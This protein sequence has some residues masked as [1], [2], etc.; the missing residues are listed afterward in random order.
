MGSGPAPDALSSGDGSSGPDVFERLPWRERV[1][2]GD[3]LRQETV[4]GALLLIAAL[5][6]LIWA[7][8]PWR[9]A[10]YDLASTKVGPAALNLNLSLSTWAA[11]GLLAIFFYVAG[12]ELKRELVVGTLRKPAEAVLPVAAALGGMIVPALIFV[13]VAWGNSPDIT[14]WGIPMATDIAFALAVLAVVGRN[15]PAQLRA[16]LLTLAVVD[17]LGAITVIALF[18]SDKTKLAWLAL[19]IGLLALFALLQHRRV[20]SAWIYVPLALVTWA[21]MHESGVHATV[22]GVA[23]G[24]LTRVRPDP[25]ETES[26]AERL[27]HMIRPWSAALAVPIFA[28][29]SA[30]VT[31]VGTDL[32]AAISDPAAQGIVLGL[33]VGKFIGIFGTTY[34]VV[35]F[36]RARLSSAMTWAD[37]AGVALVAGVGF[38]VSLLIAELAFDTD[39]TQLAHAKLGIL[40]ASVIA[41]FLASLLLLRRN[42]AYRELADLENRDD[43]GDGIPDVYQRDGTGTA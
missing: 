7:N 14:G 10:Y 30:G 5:F 19:A 33:V 28:F 29:F 37:I 40:T 22:A 21:V 18:Y 3:V 39:E 12:L 41:A 24:L 26:P 20:R 42:R 38:T 13:A 9:E 2:I 17:D 4:G 34:L 23:L 35:R 11:D 25:G 15:L 43:D 8:S 16:F 6:A 27:E 31:V 1:F 36:T 32:G